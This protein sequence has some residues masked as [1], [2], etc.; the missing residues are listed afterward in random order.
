M[1]DGDGD[2]SSWCVLCVLETGKVEAAFLC[3]QMC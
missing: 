1:A 2:G 3:L